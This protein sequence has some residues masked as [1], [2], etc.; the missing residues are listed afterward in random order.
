MC[1]SFLSS[2]NGTAANLRE[3]SA[4]VVTARSPIDRLVA[5]KEQSGFANLPV[6]S[7]MSGE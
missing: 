5:Y 6:V 1:T 3:R 4:I 2:W 7:D